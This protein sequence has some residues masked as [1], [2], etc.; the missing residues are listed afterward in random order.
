M[1]RDN[2]RFFSQFPDR[3]ECYRFSCSI[4]AINYSD[5]LVEAEHFHISDR[6]IRL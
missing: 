1:L 4:K 6:K 2:R 3:A 5:T